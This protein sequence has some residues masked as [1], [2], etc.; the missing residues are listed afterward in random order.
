[1]QP[2]ILINTR[3]LTLSIPDNKRETLIKIIL[4]TWHNTRKRFTLREIASL[5][6]LVA[7]LEKAT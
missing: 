3:I 6:G 1:M 4:T 7:Y 5:F 2:G